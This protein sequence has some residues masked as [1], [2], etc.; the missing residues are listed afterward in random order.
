MSDKTKD[1]ALAINPRRGEIWQADLNPGIGSELEKSRPVIIIN[2]PKTG[3]PTMRLCVPLTDWKADTA[4]FHW[5]VTICDTSAG[6]GCV[7]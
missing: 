2:N 7:D 6:V 1:A 3:R 5:C 4:L